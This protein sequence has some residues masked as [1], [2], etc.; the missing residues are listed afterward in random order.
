MQLNSCTSLPGKA[1]TP[2]S[3][4]N[5]NPASGSRTSSFFLRE[6]ESHGGTNGAVVNHIGL[7]FKELRETVNRLKAESTPIITQEVV[8]AVIPVD[9]DG[10]AANEA[11]GSRLAF[12]LAPNGTRVE[13]YE[14]KDLDGEVANHPHP[15]LRAGRWGDEDV[16]YRDLRGQA[17]AACRNGSGGSRRSQPDLWGEETTPAPKPRRFSPASKFIGPRQNVVLSEISRRRFAQRG[18]VISKGGA[19]RAGRAATSPRERIDQFL[20]GESSHVA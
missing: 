3:L 6:A 15:L 12:A 14:N 10:V 8:G 11:A 1:G 17:G 18:M 2:K 9:G 4:V 5:G 19:I 20:D 13:I 7:Q 16:V